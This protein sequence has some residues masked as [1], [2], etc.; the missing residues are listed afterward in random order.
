MTSRVTVQSIPSLRHFIRN[1]QSLTLYRRALRA[2]RG[3]SRMFNLCPS[4][5]QSQIN[6]WTLTP[7]R[8][9]LI[10]APYPFF[11]PSLANDRME[12]NQQIRREFENARNVTDEH[13]ISYLLTSGKRQIERMFLSIL[14]P[15]LFDSSFTRGPPHQF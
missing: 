7:I 10:S 12:V 8:M 13:H 6:S 4:K 14:S 15:T 5:L 3:L 2:T 1:S 9:S 11:L